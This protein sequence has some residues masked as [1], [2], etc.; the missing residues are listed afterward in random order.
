MTFGICWSVFC[1]PTPNWLLQLL[2]KVSLRP[3]WN[4]KFQKFLLCCQSCAL[5]LERQRRSKTSSLFT[6]KTALK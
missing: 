5:R 1:T 6:L 4:L 2:Q 3:F